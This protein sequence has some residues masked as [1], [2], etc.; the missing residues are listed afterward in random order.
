MPVLLVPRPVL[1]ATPALV[2]G[3]S[4]AVS[5]KADEQ[6]AW[7][8]TRGVVCVGIKRDGEEDCVGASRDDSSLNRLPVPLVVLLVC[9]LARGSNSVFLS[10][11]PKSR[12]VGDCGSAG[13]AGSL[14]AGRLWQVKQGVGEETRS[15]QNCEIVF[16]HLQ[17]KWLQLK[18]SKLANLSKTRTN[19]NN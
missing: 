5:P 16:R 10:C 13:L 8:E 12:R 17:L 15:A 2:G 7:V 11:S 14:V 19:P 3:A 9:P 18:R 6:S 4:S 1:Y